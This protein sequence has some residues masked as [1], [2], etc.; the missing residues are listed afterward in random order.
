[1]KFG[2]SMSYSCRHP[3]YDPTSNLKIIY[4][5]YTH[6][7]VEKDGL[8]E[9]YG[10]FKQVDVWDSLLFLRGSMSTCIKQLKAWCFRNSLTLNLDLRPGLNSLRAGMNEWYRIDMS[11]WTRNGHTRSPKSIPSPKPRSRSIRGIYE[12]NAYVT[13]TSARKFPLESFLLHRVYSLLF[14]V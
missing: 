4:T 10:S 7:S 12:L 9:G 1:M 2:W 5:V 13:Q 14:V 6:T 3:V 8:E 11:I